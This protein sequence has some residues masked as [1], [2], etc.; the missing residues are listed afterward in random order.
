MLA[1]AV[2]AIPRPGADEG[3]DGAQWAYEPKWD[4]FRAIVTRDP[5][6]ARITSR[7]GKELGGHF[8]ELVAALAEQV[9]PGCV[10]DDEVVVVVGERLEF[11]RLSERIHPAASRI[12][13]LAA[14]VPASFIAWDLLQVDGTNVMDAP[15]HERR[16]RLEELFDGIRAPLHLTRQ[17]T[18]PDTAEEWF[19]RFEGA[20]LDGIIAK[21]LDGAYEPGKRTMRKIK[22]AR[23]AD[24]VVGA[25]RLHKNSTPQRPLLGSLQLGL[26]DGEGHLCFVGV[27]SSFTTDRRAELAEEFAARTLDPDGPAWAA[28]P[29]SPEGDSPRRPGAP[30]RWTKQVKEFHLVDPCLVAEVAYEHMEGPRFRH[31]ARFRR[32]REDREASSCT[33]EQ[34]EEPVGYRLADVLAP[35]S[36]SGADQDRDGAPYQ[37]RDGAPY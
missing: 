25:W 28:H 20:G 21:P 36:P 3:A 27:A 31:S 11:E 8:P 9:P 29:W 2:P 23:E 6:T 30:T 15:F 17:T 33:Y 12:A 5:A 26:Y 16:A 19:A 18:D 32:W 1:K 4:G 13:R 37:D 10:L 14:E 7:S 24:V 34:L 35:T 22:H